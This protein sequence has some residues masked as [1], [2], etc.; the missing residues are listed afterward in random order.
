MAEAKAARVDPFYVVGHTELIDRLQQLRNQPAVTALPAS[1]LAQIDS[2]LG[3]AQRQDRAL[4]HVKEYLAQI[5]PC[6][7]RL[8]QLNELAPYPE[9][10]APR[11]PLLQRMARRRRAP[12]RGGEGHRR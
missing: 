5:E 1:E 6:R 11:R 9:I 2:I 3:E 12:P 4:S 7:T 10:G 8:H